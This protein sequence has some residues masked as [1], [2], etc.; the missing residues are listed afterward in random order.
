MTPDPSVYL[1]GIRHHGPGSAY[2]VVQALHEISPDLILVEGPPDAEALIPLAGHAEMTPPVAL[3]IYAEDDLADTAFYPFVDFSPEWQAIRFGLQQAIP[4]RFM[5]LPQTHHVALRRAAKV[6]LAEA[7][8]AQAEN[9]DQPIPLPPYL[10]ERNFP[11]DPLNLLARAAGFDDGERWWERLVE[12]RQ[13]GLSVFAGIGEAMRELRAVLEAEAGLPYR[14]ALREAWMRRTL[15]AAKAEGFTRIAVVCGAWHVPALETT[16]KE[17]E[18]A[19][20]HAK[21]DDAL[22]KGLPKCKVAATWAPWSYGRIAMASGYGAG[23]ASPGWYQ[24]LWESRSR[25]A[26]RASFVAAG[27]LAHVARLLR[28][29][30]AEVATASVIEAVRLSEALTALRN[31]PLPSLEEL[32]QAALATL[33]FGE[34]TF[35]QLIERQLVIGERLGEVPATTP[36][37]PLQADLARLQRVL[38]LKPEA[39]ERTL[40]LDLRT[41][42]GLERSQLLHRLLLLGIPW[43]QQTHA[44]GKGTFKELWRLQWQPEFAVRLIEAGVW[45]SSVESATVGYVRQQLESSKDLGQITRTIDQ[46]LLAGLPPV[47]EFAVERL[48]AEA[49]LANDVTLLMD[50]LP[51]LARVLRYGSVRATDTSV[52]THILQGFVTRIGIGLAGACYSLDDEAAQTMLNRIE[53]CHDTIHL[54]QN[55]EYLGVW[56]EAIERLATQAGLHG[57]L[58]GKCCRLL[59]AGER[60]DSGQAATRFSYA[61]SIANQPTD[62]AAW[63]EGMLRGSGLLLLHDE[64]IWRVVDEWVTALNGE[65]FLQLLPLVRRTFATFAPAERRMMGDKVK[66]GAGRGATPA[67]RDEQPFDHEAGLAALPIV[68]QM[69]GLKGCMKTTTN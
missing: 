64:R 18:N 68:I 49:A 65:T 47:V 67:G 46:A 13:E 30:G 23:V 14:E 28:D 50:A 8:A 29:E 48:Q 19:K 52:L 24:F 38:R 21:A 25:S 41:P 11:E 56:W 1:L 53:G 40:E 22:L 59:L 16:A 36:L 63:L 10:Q 57:L 17:K 6:A 62:A 32:N 3:L 42:T 37:S 31:K 54:V 2:S 51:A 27:W 44:S 55:E 15:R 39:Q 35:L 58:A 4:V 60:M 66:H 7:T 69:L 5:D 33:C 61:L 43:G 9:N 12:E 45:G 34:T 26:D 20:E